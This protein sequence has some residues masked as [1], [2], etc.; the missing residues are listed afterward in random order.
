MIEKQLLALCLKDKSVLLESVQRN[1]RAEFFTLS[2]TQAF[3]KILLW[4]N[5]NYPMEAGPVIPSQEA[6]LGAVNQS[7]LPEILRGTIPVLY[8]E[9]NALTVVEPSAF[10]FDC[11]VKDYKE[12]TLR[13]MLAGV[14]DDLDGKRTDETILKIRKTLASFESFGVADSKEGDYRDNIEERTNLYNTA[15][16]CP[17]TGIPYGFQTLDSVTGGQQKGELWV[18]CGFLKS[19]KCLKKGSKVLL[20]DGSLIPIEQVP[21]GSEVFV[22]NNDY[23][24]EKTKVLRNISNGRKRLYKINTRL[25]RTIEATD[26]HPFLTFEGWRQLKD[27]KVKDRIAL[28][29]KLSMDL[30]AYGIS[31]DSI[32][33]TSLF[34]SEGSYTGNP[35]FVNY[36]E[37]ILRMFKKS[38]YSLGL[39]C[40]KPQHNRSIG[41][42]SAK[43]GFGAKSII[44][45]LGIVNS[46]SMDKEFPSWVFKLSNQQLELLLGTYFMGDGGVEKDRIPCYYSSSYVLIRQI[47]HL[48]LRLGM[49]GQIREKQS[50][51]SKKGKYVVLDHPSYT[52][53]VG[54]KENVFRFMETIYPHIKGDKATQF[55]KVKDY[56]KNIKSKPWNDVVPNPID[57]VR[58]NH[59]EYSG[60]GKN[61][62]FST[63]KGTGRER[64]QKAAD[65]TKDAYI[66]KIAYSDIY[67]DEIV[68]I[69]E[70]TVD[71]VYDLEIDHESHNFV[72]EDFIVHNSACLLNMANH[73]WKAGHN[74]LFISAE[75]SK[76]VLERR[77]DALNSSLSSTLLKRGALSD[78]DETIYKAKLEEVKNHPSSFYIIDRPGMTTDAIAA[79]VQEFKASKNID[80]VIVDYL[81]LIT[82][83]KRLDSDWQ[84]KSQVA[85]D[86]RYIARSENIPVL[87]AHQMNREGGKKGK[88]HATQ[89]A[90]SLAILMHADLGFSIK[91][92]DEDEKQ[93]SPICTLDASIMVSRDS[94]TVSFELSA[95]FDKM[96]VLE[97]L[98]MS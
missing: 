69:E 5:K 76:R 80:L 42:S 40:S 19:G 36:D 31:D 62:L 53:Y 14:V 54:N 66:K 3:Y 63:F 95:I 48:L 73:A 90:N 44:N 61:A 23:K 22:L 10:L 88:A 6:L 27:L 24:L 84:E 86:L 91:I 58:K 12:K 29:R 41:L 68:S 70:T 97:P 2:E 75:V 77:L 50:A 17:I 71:D 9:L 38:A 1:I 16:T 25:G 33:F 96:T 35:S 13:T 65:I 93:N 39:K 57:Y 11:L 8:I 18:V 92:Q 55:V 59:I 15:K 28:P 49:N 4:F 74:V 81:G 94:A 83:G 20:S 85:L 64:L 79:K 98:K 60:R 32:R 30:P 21:P 78:E 89:I 87:T 7:T 72:C 43:K 52:L 45:S 26:N 51:Y 67:W 46:N 47:Q 37:K 34:I 56:L 82:S